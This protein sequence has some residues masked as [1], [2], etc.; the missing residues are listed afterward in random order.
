MAMYNA[1]Y[2]T[3]Y[4]AQYKKHENLIFCALSARNTANGKE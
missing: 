2:M 4:N 1:Q 3:M